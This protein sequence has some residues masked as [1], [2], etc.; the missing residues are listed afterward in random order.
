MK[1]DIT[2]RVNNSSFDLFRQFYLMLIRV[3]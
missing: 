1:T 2:Q 3:T